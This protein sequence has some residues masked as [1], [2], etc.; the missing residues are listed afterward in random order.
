MSIR[1]KEVNR[2]EAV[3]LLK[4]QRAWLA[5]LPS[6]LRPASAATLSTEHLLAANLVGGVTAGAAEE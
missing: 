1:F 3:R 5:S 6:L 4:A 2:D